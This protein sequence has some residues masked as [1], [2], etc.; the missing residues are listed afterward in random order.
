[1]EDITEK[2]VNMIEAFECD[3]N[4]YELDKIKAEGNTIKFE[5]PISR[6][7]FDDIELL[8]ELSFDLRHGNV[9]IMKVE[10]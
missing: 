5:F 1:M 8:R 3:F 10:E 4:I 2:Y 7:L 9:K 6:R